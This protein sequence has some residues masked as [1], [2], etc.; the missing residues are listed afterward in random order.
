LHRSIMVVDGIVRLLW[1]HTPG[2]KAYNNQQTYY[3]KGGHR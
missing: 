3:S 2:K 1:G